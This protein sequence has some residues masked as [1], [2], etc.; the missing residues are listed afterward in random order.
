MDAIRVTRLVVLGLATATSLS[1][2]AD[3]LV[4]AVDVSESSPIFSDTFVP[5]AA[6][7]IADKI[8]TLPL[9]SKVRLFLV[10]DDRL[11]ADLKLDLNIQRITNKD[12][13]TAAAAAKAFPAA[14]VAMLSAQELKPHK[15]SHLTTAF[16]DGVKLCA[17][18]QSEKEGRPR[19]ER[20]D[21]Y[22]LTDGAQ[23]ER[24]RI[25]YPRDVSRLPLPPVPGLDLRG[26]RVTMVGVGQQMDPSIRLKLNARWET[27]LR[28]AGAT[29]FVLRRL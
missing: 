21:I 27:W 3:A 4:I 2:N 1:A 11:R 17:D 18:Y 12:G 19:T 24:G 9:G 13:A 7:P 25:E 29:D 26:V 8:S 16:L 28:K 22:Y 5:A 15:Q 6:I 14:L 10:G 23:F 20:C